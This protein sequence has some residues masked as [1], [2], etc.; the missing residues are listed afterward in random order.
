MDKFAE[1]AVCDAAMVNF[2]EM[3]DGFSGLHEEA[4]DIPVV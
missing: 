1:V 3:T 4:F 2:T